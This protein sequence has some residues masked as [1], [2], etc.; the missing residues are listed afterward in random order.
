MKNNFFIRKEDAYDS[1]TLVQIFQEFIQNLH[2]LTNT[3]SASALFNEL[4]LRTFSIVSLL[5]MFVV[6]NPILVSTLRL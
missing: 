6:T 3:I 4:I 5:N 1:I 2:I